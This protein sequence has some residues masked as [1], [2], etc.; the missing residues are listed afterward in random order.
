MMESFNVVETGLGN[1]TD[2]FMESERVIKCDAKKFDT[3]SQWNS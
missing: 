1:E 3:L 2:M